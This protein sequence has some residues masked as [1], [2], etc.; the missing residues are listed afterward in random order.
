MKVTVVGTGCTW[1]TRNNTSFIIDDDILLD[2]PEG[3]YKDIAKIVDVLALDSI[4]ISHFHTDHF[5]DLHIIL[6]RMMRETKNRSKKLKVFAP[7]GIQTLLI[8]MNKLF[9]GA[10]DETDIKNFLDSVDFIELEDRKIFELERYNVETFKVCHGRPETFGFVFRE[11]GGKVVAFSADTCYCEN[12]ENLLKGADAAFVELSCM[13]KH[14]YHL[15]VDEFLKLVKDHKTTKIYP[16]H[17]SDETQKF[18]EENGLNPLYDG[19]VKI[20]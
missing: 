19:E 7:K 12:L 20:F 17:T 4:F 16:V 5:N 10:G 1:F 2:T 9:Y 15:C 18:V 8:N 11:K 3:A 6:T 13:K 14:P